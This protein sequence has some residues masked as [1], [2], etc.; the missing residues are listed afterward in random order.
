MAEGTIRT[1]TDR[2]FGFMMIRSAIVASAVLA[3]AF[4]GIVPGVNAPYTPHRVAAT[5][6]RVGTSAD[7]PLVIPANPYP[8]VTL[9]LNLYS[10]QPGHPPQVLAMTFPVRALAASPRGRYIALAEGEQGLWIVNSDGTGLHRLLPVPIRSTGQS[11]VAISAVAWSPDRYTLAYAVNDSAGVSTDG[12]LGIWT[13]RYDG[14]SRRH[15][16][17]GAR[18]AAGSLSWSSDGR[19]LAAG[20]REG[21]VGID[22]ATGR[23]HVLV[24]GAIDRGSGPQYPAFA[25]AGRALA[26]VVRRFSPSGPTSA[27]YLI[28]AEGRRP[29]IIVQTRNDILAPVWAPDGRGIAYVWTPDVIAAPGPPPDIHAVDLATGSTHILVRGAA[30]TYGYVTSF[31][32]MPVRS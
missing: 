31:V 17:A 16:L 27:L 25:P 12:R 4:S 30:T 6:I 8:P 9:M 20:L 5:T 3:A 22:A 13:V 15:L 7:G 29:R 18:Y 26:Y 21:L 14:G 10:L 24:A 2:G 23:T 11:H 1:M 19:T 32:W 28:D